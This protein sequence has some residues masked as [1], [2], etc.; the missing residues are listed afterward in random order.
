MS[1]SWTSATVVWNFCVVFGARSK[2]FRMHR[3]PLSP[4]DARIVPVLPL[5]MRQCSL[6]RDL[7]LPPF[8]FQTQSAY[9]FINSQQY[10][11][12]DGQILI[13]ILV[14]YF[15]AICALFVRDRLG[16]G[17]IVFLFQ[18]VFFLFTCYEP[19]SIELIPVLTF[20]NLKLRCGNSC[21]LPWSPSV[22]F[23]SEH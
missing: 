19:L 20:S 11:F 15:P 22:H 8:F 2:E 3:W 17:P 16:H 5:E 13:W 1:Q 4:S 9:V 6:S 21:K 18:A 10:A 7:S 12:Y 14:I 23:Q